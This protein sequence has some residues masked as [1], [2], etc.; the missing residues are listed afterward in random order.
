MGFQNPIV[1]TFFSYNDKLRAMPR[2]LKKELP[3]LELIDSKTIG[4][5]LLEVRK[6]KELT[7]LQLSKKIGIERR[8]LSEYETGRVNISGEMVTRFAIALEVS[9]D[10]LLGLEK[11]EDS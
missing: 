6:N 10:S 9:T 3:P 1:K 2:K 4:E 5:R 7:Q 8:L 11:I